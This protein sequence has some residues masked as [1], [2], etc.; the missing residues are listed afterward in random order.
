[1]GRILREGSGWRLGWDE[2]AERYPGLVGT[3]DWAV[4]LTADEMADFC[5]LVQ[6][7]AETIAAIASELM[8]EERLQ[9]EAESALLWLEAEGFPDAYDLRLILASDRRVEACWP[10]AAVPDLVAATHTLTAF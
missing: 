6:Q 4:E 1:M 5:R 3:T 9:I 8:P 2:A 10:A 7:L